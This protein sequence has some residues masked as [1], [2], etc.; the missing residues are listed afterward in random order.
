M[1]FGAVAMQL[2]GIAADRLEQGDRGVVLNGWGGTPGEMEPP[3][4]AVVA[5]EAVELSPEAEPRR[6]EAVA[7]ATLAK[8]DPK[9]GPRRAVPDDSPAS[10]AD[11]EPQRIPFLDDGTV[12]G[13]EPR[14]TVTQVMELV[15]QQRERNRSAFPQ[16]HQGAKSVETSLIKLQQE[17]RARTHLPHSHASEA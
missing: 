1:G 6:T 10:D 3:T 9:T 5:L 13:E 11:R 2:A 7:V 16:P 17:Y 15:V 12:D 8:P 14:I 4:A